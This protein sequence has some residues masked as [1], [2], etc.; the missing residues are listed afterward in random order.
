VTRDDWDPQKVRRNIRIASAFGRAL[1]G[2][3]LGAMLWVG[4][5][6]AYYE[7]ARCANMV[8][9]ISFDD[10]YEIRFPLDIV[11]FALFELGCGLLAIIIGDRFFDRLAGR[12]NQGPPPRAGKK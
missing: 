11:W 6:W 10:F 2:M 4:G 12:P 5:C 9:L 7:L 8:G 3:V 1:L